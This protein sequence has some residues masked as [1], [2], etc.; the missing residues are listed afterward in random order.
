[1]YQYNAG[2]IASSTM[3]TTF[4]FKSVLTLRPLLEYWEKTV[5]ERKFPAFSQSLLDAIQAAPELRSQIT[6]R[7]IIDKHTDLI[8]FLMSAAIP[9]A[10]TDHELIAATVPFQFKNIYS[11]NAFKK[12]ID[13]ENLEKAASVN[14]PGNNML[15]G[16]TIHACL[17]ILQKYYNVDVTFDKPILFTIR[18]SETGL[19]KV[20]KIEIGRQF[21][22]VVA[23]VPPQPIDAKILKFLIEK[24][25]DVDLWLQYIKPENFEFHGFM[26]FRMVDVTEQEM[27]S[28]IK[29]DLLE[30]NAVTKKE[31]FSRIQHKLRSIFNMPDIRLGLAFFDLNDNIILNSS[32]DADCWKSLAENYEGSV[33]CHNYEGSVYQ[34][35]WEEKRF[36]TIEDLDT[37]PFRTPV[38]D[39][40][41]AGGIKNILLAPLIDDGQTIGLLELASPTAGKLNP[42]SSAKV[43]NALPMFTAAVKRVKEEMVTE[44]RA[45]IQEECTNIHPSVQWKFFQAGAQ[46]LNKRRNDDKA[47]LEDIVFKEV[48]PLFG[49]AD[50][51]NSSIERNAAIQQDLQLNLRMVAELLSNINNR[52]SLPAVDEL[53]FKTNEKLARLN[54]ELASGDES[55]I[56]DFIKSEINPILTHFDADEDLKSLIQVYRESLDPELGVIYKKRKA[57]EESLKTINNMVG[58]YL[59]EVQEEA[60]RMYPHYFEKYQ[61]DGVEYTLYVGSS[62]NQGRRFDS[63]YLRNFRLWQLLAMCQ[64]DR[65]MDELK[66]QLKSKLDITQLILVH[67]QPLS[68]RFRPDEKQFDVDGAYDIRYE[69]VKKRIDKAYIKNSAERLTQPGKIAIVYNNSKIEEEYN[70]YFEYLTAKGLITS[71]VEHFELEELPGA[72]GLKAMRIAVVKDKR[73]IDSDLLKNISETFSLQ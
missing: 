25:Y 53:I 52:T 5:S 9:P 45:L 40:L 41:R 39:F 42:V 23:T 61:T 19:D 51:R 38:E 1:L 57:F 56:L 64:I 32:D 66:P 62:I 59:D 70:R 68:I 36:I 27:I 69:I 4:P 48:Y 11:T 34:R 65:K 60:Q 10:Q 17:M 16:K 7:S 3:M 54:V 73:S 28:S 8:E 2:S 58:H 21:F 72:T 44:V 14:I 22:D 20:Y 30:K 15:V 71:S 50:V 67:D 31:T 26:I 46:L 47:V 49:L 24:V 29:Y 6:N 33:P 18:N 63:F 37:F 43:E 35:S 12:Y 55:G 13:F